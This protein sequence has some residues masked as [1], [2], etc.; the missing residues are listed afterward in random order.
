M[1]AFNA[2]DANAIPL[3]ASCPETGSPDAIRNDA[4]FSA[5]AA[6]MRCVP[7]SNI[8]IMTV[9]ELRSFLMLCA[10]PEAEAEHWRPMSEVKRLLNMRQGRPR[11]ARLVAPVTDA[12]QALTG[13]RLTEAGRAVRDS[14][15][16]V[17]AS[18]QELQAAAIAEVRAAVIIDAKARALA[19]SYLNRAIGYS[20]EFSYSEDAA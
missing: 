1:N 5:L 17:W 8:G 10:L 7:D 20:G 19:G 11:P 12:S 4:T 2:T 18:A 15:A 6:L 3:P 9:A 14:M 13:F 16:D